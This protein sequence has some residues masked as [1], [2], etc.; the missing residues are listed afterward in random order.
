MRVIS[1][2]ARGCSLFAPKGVE[3]RPTADSV[4]ESLFNI[5][6]ADV[7]D[8]RFL[9]LFAGSGAIGIEALS[10]G[11][12]A[13]C[14]VENSRE[15]CNLI[16]KNLDKTRLTSQSRLIAA[17]FIT[18]IDKLR[19]ENEYFDIIFLDPPYK[20]GFTAQALNSLGGLLAEDGIIIAETAIE[21]DAPLVHGL[22]L[23]R[24]KEYRTAKFLFYEGEHK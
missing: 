15:A 9:D 21:E 22:R 23:Y 16:R 10:R 6:A 8:S 14:F 13:C 3:T 24:T 12:A 18:A 20:C 5:I 19:R 7:V 2:S 4:K 1:G 17:D 11:A